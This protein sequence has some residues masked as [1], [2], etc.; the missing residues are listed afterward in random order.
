MK[1]SSII[2][3]TLILLVA[4][5]NNTVLGQA[6]KTIFD[7][8]DSNG[9][10]RLTRDELPA[11]AKPNFDRAD[12]DKDGFISREEDTLFRNQ[13]RQPGSKNK[14][15]TPQTNVSIKIKSDIAYAGTDNPR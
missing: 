9:D 11:N 14:P 6:K 10:G 15:S 5:S 12:G 4:V 1:P 2:I 7:R 13:L 8:W 3:P